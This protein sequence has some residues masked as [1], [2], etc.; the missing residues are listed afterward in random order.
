MRHQP[1]WF[2]LGITA[3]TVFFAVGVSPSQ[4][5][6]Q[7]NRTSMWKKVDE[8]IQKGLPKTA[9]DELRPIIASALADK[10]FPEAI[11]AIA[12][13]ISLTGQ[14][15]GGSPEEQIRLMKTELANSPKEM[16]PAMNAIMGYWYWAYFEQHRWQFAN[17]TATSAAPSDDF[18]TWDLT[19]LFAEIDKHYSIALESEEELKKIPIAAYDGLLEKGTF[20]DSYR[21]TLYDFLAFVAIDFYASGEQ[22]GSKAEDTFEIDASGA[23]L[24]STDD[25]LGWKP[26][27]TDS[28]SPKLKAIQLYQKLLVFHRNDP[29]RSAFL[30]A[31]LGRL[32]FAHANAYGEEKASRYKSS[33]KNFAE[34]NAKHELSSTA[35][36]R[37]AEILQS[38]SDLI[39]AREVALQGKNAFP[40]SVGGKLCANLIVGI[41]SKNLSILTER[42]WTDP[43]PVLRVRYRNINQVFFRAVPLDWLGRFAQDR[44][45]PNQINEAD[46]TQWL[47]QKAAAAWSS[48]LP[49]TEDFREATFDVPAPNTLKPGYYMIIASA[50]QDFADVDN[51]VSAS[52]VWVTNLALIVRQ[53]WGQPKLDGFVLNA[54]SG[55]PIANAKVRSFSRDNRTR[56]MIEGPPVLTNADGM[57]SFASNSR[58]LFLLASSAGNE[59]ASHSEHSIVL[60]PPNPEV[61]VQHVLFT[62]R[63]IYRPGQTVH[64]KG[65]SLV[66][67]QKADKYVVAAGRNVTVKFHDP[68]GQEIA[69]LP[70]KTNDY[71]SYSGTFTAPRDRGTGQMMIQVAEGNSSSIS[72]RVEEYKRP[73]FQVTVEPPK[74]SAKL[75]GEVNLIGKA[76]SY[77]GAA[78]NNAKV[79]YRVTREVRW[80]RWFMSCFAWR[81]P[82]MIGQSQEIA[83]GWTNTEIDGTFKLAFVAKPDRSVPESDQPSFHYTVTADVTDSTGETRTGS[84]WIAVG[85]TAIEAN[86]TTADWLVSDQDTQLKLS[87]TTLDG[88]GQSA[89]GIL[90]IHRLKEPETIPRS[91]LLGQRIAPSPRG[92]GRLPKGVP[93]APAPQADLADP[94]H[95][96]LGEVIETKTFET[97]EEGKLE[98][99][100]KLSRGHYRA[101][102]ETQDRFGK[103]VTAQLN[104]RVIDPKSDKLG[105][106]LANLL[107]APKWKLEPGEKL[108]AVWG[109]GYDAARAYVEIEFQGKVLQRFWTKPG[110]TQVAIEQSIVESMRGGLT[111][112]TTCIR[113]NRAHLESRIIEVPW[114]NKE[115]TLKW[116]RFV[117]K[118]EP[119]A[120]ETYT[121]TISGSNATRATAEMVA[122]LY[123]ASLDAFVKQEW[124]QRFNVF[125]QEY[126]P[127][128]SLFNNTAVY[129]NPFRGQWNIEYLAVEERYRIFPNDIRGVA[130]FR[131]RGMAYG[132]MPGA[133][134]GIRSMDAMSAEGM[135]FA[136]AA[137]MAMSKSATPEL[138]EVAAGA[139]IEPE[140]V[141]KKLANVPDLTSV[142][143]RT[144]LNETAFFFPHL[145]SNSEGVVKME[146]TMP[147]ALTKWRFLGFSHDR[148]LRSGY[149]EDSVVTSKDLMVQPNTPR[150]LREG[151][152]LEFS[153]KVMNQSNKPQAG[154]VALRLFDART[155]AAVDVDFENK[156]IEKEFEIPAGE[157]KSYFWKLRVPDGAY[158]II[159]KAVGATDKLSDGEEG[160]LPV[161]SKRILVTESLPLPIRG[162]STREFEFNKLLESASSDS[163]Q[164]QSLSIQMTSQ[165]AWYAVLA[166]PYL[167]EF[168]HECSEQIFN[169]FYA[170]VLAHHIAESDPKIRR[171]FETWK[172]LQPA[173]LDS[174]LSKNQ[175]IKS[176]MI[177][178]TP[179]LRDADRE[180]ES[181]R[182]LGVLFDESRLNSE[183]G[184]AL[185]Q[186]TE[187]QRDNGMWP[188]FS[189]GPDNE[190]LSLYIVTG[191]GRL[192]QLKVN[193]DSNI[194]I[195][196]IDRLDA[197]VHEQYDRILRDS[198]DPES[199]HLSSIIA[200]YL[201]GRSFF[202]SEKPIGAEHRTAIEYWQR[203]AR[204]YWLQIGNRQSQAHIA[205]GLQRL[206]DKET[207]K[208]ILSSLKE[209]S[210]SNEEMGMYWRDTERS[211]WWYDAPIES[212]A[213]MIEAFDEVGNDSAAVEDCKVWLL[214]QKQTQ[215]WKT[216]KATADA[217]YSLLLRGNNILGSDSLVQLKLANSLIKPVNVESGTGFYEQKFSRGEIKPEMGKITLTK[218]DDGVSWGSIHWQYLEEVSKITPHEGT[219]LKLEKK[220]FK[221]TFSK[222]GPVLEAVDGPLAVGDE[223]VCRVVLRSDRDMEYVH[224][225]DHRG[226]G[227]EPVNVLSNYKFQ[228]GLAYYE[229]T[230]DTASHFFIDYLRKGT[231]VFEYALRVQHSGR[232]PSGLASI[233][234]MYAPEFNSHSESVLMEVK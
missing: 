92:R 64:F 133:R 152:T 233:E 224:L 180:S 24:G 72:I 131:M 192:K 196:A 199:N 144:N 88:H 234:C 230:R 222:S 125:R 229:S 9:I 226:S 82:P 74:E 127:L 150:F 117:S 19:R 169:R 197:W 176:V 132:G 206:G 93:S 130:N 98:L 28:E 164:H 85:Y 90:R 86:I 45:Q 128:N 207:P 94:T 142:S 32:R 71:G 55:E 134:G 160:M 37:L 39:Q 124:Q 75:G 69:T 83:H 22:A 149:L 80:P 41:E 187:M 21:P 3:I 17:R 122:A 194:A 89:K 200:L 223:V 35:R 219:P 76:T 66:A 44:W 126:S 12:K 165:P 20:P 7:T 62:D 11:K 87:T 179:W 182:N 202:L 13:R 112:R 57:F 166:L 161:L 216:T 48:D 151:D 162:K 191:F 29:D 6:N 97:S 95:W 104:M 47:T 54:K 190:Y 23:A 159:Y 175:D 33:L 78:I 100:S 99:S 34:S 114:S 163:L 31:E 36:H 110:V 53:S 116:D 232:Y 170:N 173:A 10:A 211:W 198:K 213:I 15:E 136:A 91:D 73:K 68:N 58:D 79:R 38:E 129:L 156:K 172:N 153:V 221:R 139:A 208:A 81:L 121:L 204:K 189:G 184:R 147:E 137:P 205:I 155:N 140:S 210:V 188:W 96:E 177:E 1:T 103:P 157:S 193:V 185:N 84:N 109:S 101:I 26:I 46:R 111:I 30:D 8:A 143:T 146:F 67:D 50:R 212:Q 18:Q 106:K 42:I 118:L 40:Q 201:Y 77:T 60:Q 56:K 61:Q 209:R 178:E 138:D 115:L 5:P 14:I 59:I 181:R 228:D 2:V 113:E 65:I 225:K 43:L 105:L 186:L 63:A 120:R 4:A 183:V 174:P 27:T 227:T 231:Y 203:Q 49:A 215:N 107:V 154:K 108:Q 168:P 51:S 119:A 16:L 158:P 123:D 141:P 218:E 217:V 145:V 52:E 195:K 102:L 70:L 171:V 167:M 214:K 135:N 220:L 148:E 25:F